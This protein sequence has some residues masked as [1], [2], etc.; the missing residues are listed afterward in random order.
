MERN[1]CT[2]YDRVI[3]CWD[4]ARRRARWRKRWRTH[5]VSR[6]QR[7]REPLTSTSI[8]MFGENVA[9][10]NSW[11][12][13]KSCV[14]DNNLLLS[15][16]RGDG[17]TGRRFFSDN[18]SIYSDKWKN[19]VPSHEM[20]KASFA[21]SW[22]D[23]LPLS[24][25]FHNKSTCIRVYFIFD[26]ISSNRMRSYQHLTIALDIRLFLCV[27]IKQNNKICVY[28]YA[29]FS[30]IKSPIVKLFTYLGIEKKMSSPL[31][32]TVNWSVRR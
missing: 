24:F 7:D 27:Y 10:V 21:Q 14:P 16:E 17:G 12:I 4:V 25:Y 30:L 23:F 3:S 5:G 32:H 18:L 13:A 11:F 9:S 19:Y 22:R 29:S 20:D 1:E 15:N 8:A 28:T 26:T 2:K 31:Y 6:L